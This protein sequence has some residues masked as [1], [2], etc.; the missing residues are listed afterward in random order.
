MVEGVIEYFLWYYVVITII[1]FFVMRQDKR[2]AQ[3][4]GRRT[5]EQSL[6]TWA[7]FGGALGMLIAS[8]MFRHKTRKKTFSIGLPLLVAI[9]I[10]L[11]VFLIWFTEVLFG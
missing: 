3:K 1:A 6:F 5:S 9:H 7:A 8:K 4:N 2:K 10:A 11:F